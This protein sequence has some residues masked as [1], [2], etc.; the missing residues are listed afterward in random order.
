MAYEA[1]D[2]RPPLVV[3]DAKGLTLDHFNSPKPEGVEGMILK[4]VTGL[5]IINSQGLKNI[6]CLPSNG[7]ARIV[8]QPVD[9]Y[10]PKN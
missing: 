8:I 9:H 5:T 10:Y 4:E 3:W 2:F 1:P 7:P 6:P